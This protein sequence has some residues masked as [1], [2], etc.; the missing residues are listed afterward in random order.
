MNISIKELT[1][2]RSSLEKEYDKLEKEIHALYK[3]NKQNEAESI[4]LKQDKVDY[5]ID[6][7]DRII[8]NLENTPKLYEEYID[9]GEI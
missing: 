9:L 8:T 7:I 1:T 4:I 5:K 2:M 6:L 3:D